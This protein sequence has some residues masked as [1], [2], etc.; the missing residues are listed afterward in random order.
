MFNEREAVGRCIGSLLEQN[1]PAQRIEILV[2]DGQSTDGSREY[3]EEI[4]RKFS[5]VRLLNNPARSTPKGLNIG[6][7]HAQGEIVIILGAHTYVEKS[8]VRLNVEY[9]RKLGV[10]CVGGTQVNM[11]E[12]YLQ[13]AIG[14]AMSSPFGIASAPYRFQ[15][16]EKY[17]D[18]VVYAAY[19]REVFDE[20]G[21]FDEE[22]FIS[23]DAE[24]N[25]RIRKAG[26]RIFFTPRIVSYYFHRK[27]IPQVIKQFFRYGILR[28]NVVKKHPDAFKMRHGI[29]PTFV[30]SI[31]ATL[32]LG[33]TNPV[34]LK[35][36]G[37][38]WGLYFTYNLIA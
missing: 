1:Y 14:A 31:I 32:L 34:F 12:T 9:M 21:Y 15:K 25:W 24:L 35:A 27:T 23:E 29:P 10:K 7:H 8:F 18:T 5:N 4:T 36:H 28:I 3:V 2:V 19:R 16:K 33:L 22:L 26:H 20:V 6:I 13:M 11:G 17:V 37:G 30:L 38:I